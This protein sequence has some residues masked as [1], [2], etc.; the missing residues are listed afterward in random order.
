MKKYLNLQ[1]FVS[2]IKSLEVNESKVLPTE[3]LE[4]GSI[5]NHTFMKI[6]FAGETIVLYEFYAGG[7]GIIQDTPVAP[8]EDYAEAV[9]E[10][11]TVSGEHHMYIEAQ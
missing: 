3:S 10:D 2:F 4:D 1:D 11:L 9:F 6:Q 8:W 5:D 7:V